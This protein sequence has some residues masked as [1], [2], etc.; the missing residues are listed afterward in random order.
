MTSIPTSRIAVLILLFS[1]LPNNVLAAVEFSG[2]DELT[3][4]GSNQNTTEL[5]AG[6]QLNSR[7]YAR[8]VCGVFSRLGKLLLRYRLS[9]SFSVEL[10]AG[11]NQ[12]M[13]LLYTIEKE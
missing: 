4:G 7:L 6:K 5:I 9:A 13:D 3:I 1:F 8:Y 10:G 11:E 12:S 2:L